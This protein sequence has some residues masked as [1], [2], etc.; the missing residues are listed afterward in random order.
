[1]GLLDSIGTGAAAG[2]VGGPIGSIIGAGLGLFGS[3]FGAHEQSA[4]AD[5]AAQIQA[6]A[7]RYAADQARQAN[8]EALAFQKAQADRDFQ[9]S[10]TNRRA[11]YDQWAAREARVGTLAQ[12]AGLPA[13]QI[14]AYVS[15][16]T[17]SAPSGAVSAATTGVKG[18]AADLKAMIDSG[19]DPQQA[20][21]KFNQQFGRTTGNEAQFYGADVHGTPTI[22]LPDAYLSLE[23]NGWSITQRGGGGAAAPAAAVKPA[24]V[25]AAMPGTLAAYAQAP[26]VLTPAL[27]MPGTLGS[28][29]S[30]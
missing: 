21:Q 11:N 10:E 7:A 23:P 15:L 20:A 28:Y 22:G 30:Y 3:L 14:P 27:Q 1:M 26:Q 19:M 17:G 4:A 18:T 16:Q 29:R 25:S 13:R 5:K 2:S 8:E 24:P 6:D 12:L 9:I